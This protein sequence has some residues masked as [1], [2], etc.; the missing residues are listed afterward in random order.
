[1]ARILLVEDDGVL[2]E[3]L[4]HKLRGWGHE[5]DLASDLQPAYEALRR[6][7]PQL[8]LSDIILPSGTG[9]DLLRHV[10][11][12]QFGLM[13]T[14]VILISSLDDQPSIHYGEL[15]GAAD[16]LIKPIDYAVLKELVDQRLHGNKN[17]LIR[18]LLSDLTP[19]RA[20]RRSDKREPV[21]RSVFGMRR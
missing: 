9:F 1:M 21:Q 7:R 18:T 16:Y 13:D 6:R 20:G 12:K 14:P 15:C 8:I 10:G 17:W 3:D 19:W 5:T 2:R 4:G 11:E